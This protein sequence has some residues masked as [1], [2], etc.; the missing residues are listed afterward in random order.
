MDPSVSIAASSSAPG[1]AESS[2]A[3]T[4]VGPIRLPLEID[5]S[6]SYFQLHYYEVGGE[7]WVSASL[8]DVRGPSR[9]PLRIESACFFGHVFGS[10]Q[11]DCGFQLEEAFRRIAREGRGL[12]IYAVDQD[13]R[14][15]GLKSHFQVY[16][17]RQNHGLDTEEVFARLGAHLDNRSYAAVPRILKHVGAERILL[18]S[19]NPSRLAFLTSAGIDVERER[20]EAAIDPYNM[21]TLM[22]EKE[23]LGYQW[24]FK[25]HSDWLRPL[26]E[27]VEGDPDLRAAAVVHANETCVA[28]WS[29]RDWNVAERLLANAPVGLSP[30]IIYLSDLPRLDELQAYAAYGAQFVVVPFASLPSELTRRAIM[31]GIKLQDWERENRYKTD[32]PQWIPLDEIRYRRGNDIREISPGR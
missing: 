32:R 1:Q 24:T 25:T 18:L 16:D 17:Y 23:D 20:H 28:E 8:G 31:L 29:G 4:I 10:R 9:V 6:V 19:N 21:A 15:L 12:V 27:R 14:G 13:A 11:C 2:W 7:R 22:L 30:T 5:G 26:Q 3:Q